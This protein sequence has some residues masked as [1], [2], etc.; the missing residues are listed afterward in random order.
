MTRVFLFTCVAGVTAMA[1]G[2]SGAQPGKPAKT[3]RY[4]SDIQPILSANCFTCHGPDA[5]SRKAGLRLDLPEE[6]TRKLKS[7]AAAI[8]P[9]DPKASELIARIFSHEDGERMPPAKSKKTLKDS[10]KK[11]LVRW[12]EEGASYQKHWAFDPPVLPKVPAVEG[13]RLGAQSDRRFRPR[14]ARSGGTHAGRARRIVT[15][16]LGG[17]RSI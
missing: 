3:V 7:G 10:E 12:I 1:F 11:L 2:Q 13:G 8:V 6:A 17:L 5:R 14:P 16:W 15:R 9:G 4:A